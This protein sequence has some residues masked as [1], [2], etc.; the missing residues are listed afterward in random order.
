METQPPAHEIIKGLQTT[1]DLNLSPC[2]SQ[3]RP[4][5]NQQGAPLSVLIRHAV[6]PHG[7]F[8]DRSNLARF[9]RDTFW[10]RIT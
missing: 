4:H 3:L 7:R 2:Q 5:R 6:F 8:A 9:I 1:S 10:Q